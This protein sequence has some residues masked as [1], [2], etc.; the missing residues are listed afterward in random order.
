ME[1]HHIVQVLSDMARA[2][3]IGESILG[4]MRDPIDYY[5]QNTDGL[6]LCLSR[7]G[8]LLSQWRGYA[9]DGA[10][11]SLGFSGTYLA[12]LC[13]DSLIRGGLMLMPVVYDLEAQKSELQPLFDRLELMID[14]GAFAAPR[15]ASLMIPED[16]PDEEASNA[17]IEER[18][19]VAS[20]S[21]VSL[22]DK[23]FKFKSDAFSE[24]DE[25]RLV[26][27]AM[28]NGKHAHPAP[29]PVSYREAN[30]KI[31]PYRE[32][33]LADMGEPVIAEVVL[34]PKNPTPL[35]VVERF[36]EASGFPN[37]AVRYSNA[38]YR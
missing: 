1:G 10:G 23:F 16:D 19:R 24:E 6:A 20:V 17:R 3:G 14:E 37:V 7:K 30:G 21:L 32:V 12:A 25:V 4:R 38:T 34:G 31:V 11:F 29:S 22:L 9:N 18:T 27:Y 36:L 35:T 13:R 8:D 15:H 26:S 33:E 5:R 28:H 2:S